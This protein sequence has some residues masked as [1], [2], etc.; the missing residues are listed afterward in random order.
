MFKWAHNRKMNKI[1]SSAE[2]YVAENYQETTRKSDSVK[3][4]REMMDRAFE[5]YERMMSQKENSTKETTEPVELPHTERTIRFSL[6]DNYDD[7]LIGSSIRAS[8]LTQTFRSAKKALD[9]YADMSFVDKMQE[10]IRTK[11]LRDVDV[12][13]AAQIDRRLYSKLMS[14]H[15]YKPSK[16]TC[17]ALAL[18]LKLSM[19]QA[20]DLL[21]RAGYALSH[22]NKRDLAIEYCFA[23]CI[24]D[25]N[26]VNE[27]L[28]HLDLKTMG[29]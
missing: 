2:E 10:Y 6:S 16:D 26:D 7:E 22:S 24:Y 19:D 8:A 12:Y 14:D 11:N 29:R 23:D 27:L 20:K 17:I 5:V 21:T 18:A 1:I 25:V 28:Y 15:T 13:K 4:S 9:T 3:A